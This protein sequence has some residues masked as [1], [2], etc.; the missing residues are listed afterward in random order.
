M[1]NDAYYGLNDTHC[2]LIIVYGAT[3]VRVLN[4]SNQAQVQ[5]SNI[6]CAE[7]NS[8]IMCMISSTFESIKF[9]SFD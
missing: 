6:S 9:D 8:S 3:S 2:V 5:T 4:V 1:Y 7:Y